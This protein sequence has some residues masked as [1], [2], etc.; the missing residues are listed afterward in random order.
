MLILQIWL[1]AS[2]LLAALWA[3]AGLLIGTPEPRPGARENATPATLGP[4]PQ[5]EAA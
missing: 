1:A 3:L 2:L 4:E 5:G